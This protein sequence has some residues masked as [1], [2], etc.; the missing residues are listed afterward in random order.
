ML[1]ST[2]SSARRAYPALNAL[3]QAQAA[4]TVSLAPG[5]DNGVSALAVS[6]L[7]VSDLAVSDLLVCDAL[8]RFFFLQ[9]RAA[10]PPNR[11][12]KKC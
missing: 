5:F 9:R 11:R 7:A 12:R 1:F 3:A 4:R 2:L 10:P 6:D 8:M